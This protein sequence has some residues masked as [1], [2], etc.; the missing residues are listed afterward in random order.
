MFGV[1]TQTAYASD[2]S[3]VAP[4]ATTLTVDCQGETITIDVAAGTTL[5]GL[6]S[7]INGDVDARDKFEASIMNDGSGSYLVLTSTE[8]GSSN[9]LAI[10]G[11]GSL[12]GMST[13]GF[14]NTQV[15][16]SSQIKVD[17]FPPGAND[18][19]ERDS[20]SI[21]DVVDGLTFKLKD[22]T[23]GVARQV[24]VTYDADDMAKTITSSQ[25]S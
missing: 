8:A 23:G 15:G 7:T 20:N 3:L 22:T 16:Q 11:T 4:A 13:A 25:R 5:E 10:T 18:W 1:N 21:D 17:G 24:S 2:D 14:T 9:T 6:V 12:V 19:I